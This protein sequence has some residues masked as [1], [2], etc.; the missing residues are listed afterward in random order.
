M[1][2]TY[3]LQSLKD[4]RFYTGFTNDLRKRVNENSKGFNISTKYRRPMKLVYY[5]ACL[6]EDDARQRERTLKSGKGKKY[7]TMRLKKYFSEVRG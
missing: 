2:Y 1:W 6:N 7:I 3:I 4:K 5:E